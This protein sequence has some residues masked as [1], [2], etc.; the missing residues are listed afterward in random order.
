MKLVL[1]KVTIYMLVQTDALEWY[2]L[3]LWLND[4]KLKKEKVFS[5]IDFFYKKKNF[6]EWPT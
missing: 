6:V 3:R 1:I 5:Y 2:N 4:E